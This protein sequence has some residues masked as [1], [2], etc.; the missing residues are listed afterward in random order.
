[1]KTPK[2]QVRADQRRLA[3]VAVADPAENLRAEQDADVARREH[4]FE[5]AWRHMPV[6]NQMRRGKRDGADV[7]AVDKRDQHGPYQHLDLERAQPAFVQ[8]S[9]NLYDFADHCFP[10]E[11]SIAP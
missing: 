9:R 6:G 7:I 3:A 1:V 4:P 5:V 8:Q 2:K 10:P 11:I